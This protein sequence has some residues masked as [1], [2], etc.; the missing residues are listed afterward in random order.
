MFQDQDLPI[1]HYMVSK[2]LIPDNDLVKNLCRTGLTYDSCIPT[3]PARWD[4]TVVCYIRQLYPNSQPRELGYNN[5]RQLYPNSQPR[6]L[7]Y[8]CRMSTYVHNFFATDVF[9]ANVKDTTVVK[10]S[11]CILTYR[12]LLGP[13][14]LIH[15]QH[16]DRPTFEC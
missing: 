7:G 5:I 3:I 4:T 1:D 14:I 13:S 6:E 12:T 10:M 11:Y 15:L 16:A 9:F 2:C 8:N